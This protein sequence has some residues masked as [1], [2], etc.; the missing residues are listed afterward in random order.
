MKTYFKENYILGY[1]TAILPSTATAAL[2][3][4]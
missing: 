4:H 1:I 2:L 3:Q